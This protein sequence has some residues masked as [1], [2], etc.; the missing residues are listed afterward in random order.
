[1]PVTPL[2]S[3]TQDNSNVFVELEVPYLRVSEDT[4]ETYVEGRT[5]R[6]FCKPY[7]LRLTFPY[8]L[9]EDERCVAVFDPSVKHGIVRC[10]LVKRVPGQ[11]FPDLDLLT[12]MLQ[13]RPAPKLHGKIEVLDTQNFT[14]EETSTDE[15]DEEHSVPTGLAD[16]TLIC[17]SVRRYGF[18]RQ[19]SGVF[20]HM[21]E[22]ELYEC[23][24]PDCFIDNRAAL[25]LLKENSAFDSRRYLSD[26]HFATEDSIFVE[27]MAFRAHWSVEWDAYSKSVSDNSISEGVFTEEETAIMR[28]KL[29]NRDY[30]IA[31]G[32]TEESSV[33]LDL[34]DLL[35]A[36]CYDVRI[37]QGEGSV[38]SPGNIVRISSVLSWF[39]NYDA[40]TCSLFDV[41]R[42]CVRRCLVYPYLRS[43]KLARKV[44]ED[45][46]KLFLLGKRSILK[47]L[48]YAY[49][50]FEHSEAYYLVNQL[51]LEDY[52]VWV[53]RVNGT[54][55]RS[56]GSSLNETKRRLTKADLGLNIDQI[57]DWA[58]RKFD[59]DGCFIAGD[60][61]DLDSLHPCVDQSEARHRHRVE[62]HIEDDEDRKRTRVSS[63]ATNLGSLLLEPIDI[64][65]ALSSE[66]SSLNL[67]R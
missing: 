26:L 4:A 49:I 46:I 9:S 28:N 40:R 39:D 19:Y 7:L 60:E 54:C 33:L 23:G 34:V 6:F 8:D 10:T 31:S 56:L 21:A 27:G 61:S 53:Q 15:L 57:E 29:R 5:F 51:F 2:F 3:L 64:V 45:V 35:F 43:W 50:A 62:Q 16:D 36:I 25:K 52:C 30:L 17:E 41:L 1:M 37:T 20:T 22:A 58:M 66:V 63:S 12:A 18:N 32:S 24:H 67:G 13:S 14:A 65:S 11:H 48:M 59:A 55:L 44:L 38:E 47:T 42:S